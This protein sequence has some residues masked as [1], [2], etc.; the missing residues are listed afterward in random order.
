MSEQN[1]TQQPTAKYKLAV[2]GSR[3][4]KNEQQVF[5]ILDA[6]KDSITLVISGGATGADTLAERWADINKKSKYIIRPDWHPNGKYDKG[7]GFK[8]NI[9]I[10]K[11]CDRCIAFWDGSSKGTMNTIDH[12]LR[13]QK[14]YFVVTQEP[15]VVAEP[16]D[17]PF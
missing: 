4:F 3:E 5:Q 9:E 15:V 10:V 17:S 16:V 7:A 8:R 13:L 14:P 12:C 11:A 6:A 2:V 1:E